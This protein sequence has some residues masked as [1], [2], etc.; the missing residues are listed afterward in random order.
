MQNDFCTYVERAENPKNA[1]K[2]LKIVIMILREDVNNI[3]VCVVSAGLLKMLSKPGH[4]IFEIMWKVRDL[5][6]C[7]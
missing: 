2:V 4:I 1:L 5:F 6:K 7:F 3:W